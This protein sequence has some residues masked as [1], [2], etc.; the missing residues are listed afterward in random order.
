M[1]KIFGSC[2]RNIQIT[3]R[4]GR[5]N[6]NTDALSRC[7]VGGEY[8]DTSVPDVQ[9]AQIQTAGDIPQLLQIPPLVTGPETTAHYSQDQE[10]DPEVQEL[11][12]FLFKGSYLMTHKELRRLLPRPCHLL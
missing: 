2:V 9:I 5:E 7:P 12:L 10:K 8:T 1:S 3:Y 6:S 4:A 11:R